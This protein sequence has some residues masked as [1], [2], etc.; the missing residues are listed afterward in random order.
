MLCI[1]HLRLI[2]AC[3]RLQRWP[4]NR[5]FDS[6]KGGCAGRNVLE[7]NVPGCRTFSY[8]MP[9]LQ[10]KEVA[11]VQ[12]IE[13]S[14][15]CASY[16]LDTFVPVF[17]DTETTGLMGKTWW[18]NADRIVQ[19]ASHTLDAHGGRNLELRVNPWPKPMSPGAQNATGLST[20]DVW[21]H[22]LP[23]QVKMPVLY[24]AETYCGIASCY[25]S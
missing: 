18:S 20:E 2:C 12:Q 7:V 19:I 15:R 14:L 4:S 3:T 21:A 6:E 11:R 16:T 24:A 1:V 5:G 25:H 22:P 13:E 8:E 10:S 17:W 9:G 23:P